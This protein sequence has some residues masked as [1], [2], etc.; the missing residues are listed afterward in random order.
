MTDSE[1]IQ[2]HG[3]PTKLAAKLGFSVHRVGNWCKR[4]IPAAV[5]LEFPKLFLRKPPKRAARG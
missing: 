4:G 3:G 1:L 5:K 2:A